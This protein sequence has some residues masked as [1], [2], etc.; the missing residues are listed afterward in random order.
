MGYGFLGAG[1]LASTRPRLLVIVPGRIFP[2]EVGDL[3]RGHQ[4]NNR[5]RD[6]VGHIED[7]PDI[8]RPLAGHSDGLAPLDRLETECAQKAEHRI[9]CGRIA[10][11]HYEHLADIG[12]SI[13]HRPRV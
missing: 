8:W 11:V 4:D 9:T 7:F 5:L 6:I 10:T 2:A 13:R 1:R 12:D 3:V